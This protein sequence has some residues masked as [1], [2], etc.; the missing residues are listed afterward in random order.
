MLV[1][2]IG[3][4]ELRLIKDGIQL[5]KEVLR[6]YYADGSW[7]H[8]TSQAKKMAKEKGETNWQAICKDELNSSPSQL[9]KEF[10]ELSEQMYTSLA[11]ELG[12]KLTGESYFPLS[13]KLSSV[14]EQL[15]QQ[16]HLQ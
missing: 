6:Q 7:H 13:L 3:P 9:P 14:I 11:N 4:D 8:A 5:S 12:E 2:T 1:D 15:K 16:T 10:K